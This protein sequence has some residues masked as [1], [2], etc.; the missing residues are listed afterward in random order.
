MPCRCGSMEDGPLKILRFLQEKKKSAGCIWLDR[1]RL[2]CFIAHCYEIC[3]SGIAGIN[4][5]PGHF[6]RCTKSHCCWQNSQVLEQC[7]RT[8]TVPK[9]ITYF[10]H[11]LDQEDVF[12]E[13][14]EKNNN[15]KWSNF[16]VGLP[17]FSISLVLFKITFIYGTGESFF[18]HFSQPLQ[19]A[20]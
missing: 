17:L 10:L 18:Q 2:H 13:K 3:L 7:W 11:Q 16:V 4:N 9:I 8:W 5:H 19:K 6:R 1:N 15:I 12:R 14:K 20:L